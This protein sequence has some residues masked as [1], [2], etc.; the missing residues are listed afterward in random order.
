MNKNS[1][2]DIISMVI[3]MNNKGFTLIELVAVVLI[4]ATILLVSFP[5]FSNM[6]KAD[7]EKKYDNMV[8]DLCFAGE[9]YIYANI[10]DF[11]EL[12]TPSS[13]ISITIEELV[14]YG[15]IKDN[16]TNPRTN[17]SVSD[18]E[19]IFTVLS[20]NSLSCEYQDK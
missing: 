11:K 7:E 13:Q 20:D 9:S 12:L 17:T 10:D 8:K 16:L 1:N 5:A 14:A 15:N 2:Y 18:D 4:L 3:I 6:A 19:L